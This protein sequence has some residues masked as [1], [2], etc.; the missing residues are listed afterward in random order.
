MQRPL[1]FLKALLHPALARMYSCSSVHL[2]FLHSGWQL[3]PI[4]SLLILAVPPS[5]ASAA[6]CAITVET[7]DLVTDSEGLICVIEQLDS[8]GCCPKQEA[9]MSAGSLASL[10]KGSCCRHY[11]ACVHGCITNVE[12]RDEVFEVVR[13]NRFRDALGQTK[14]APPFAICRDVCRTHSGS[15]IHGNSFLSEHRFC[16]GSYVGLPPP[17]LPPGIAVVAATQGESCADTCRS[18]NQRCSAEALPS[19]N[20][21]PLLTKH[22]KC[23]NGCALNVGGDQPAY[24]VLANDAHFGKCLINSD[25]AFFSCSGKHVNTR[26]LCPCA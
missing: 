13:Q 5:S 16:Y 8:N 21:C 7:T 4:L 20:T 11:A 19:I 26:R 2:G 15:I 22:F 17:P 18:R 10:C 23:K 14:N 12:S 9:G 3:L 1:K 25:P 24:V 6:R